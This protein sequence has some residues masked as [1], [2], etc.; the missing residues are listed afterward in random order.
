MRPSDSVDPAVSVLP[1]PGAQEKR[2]PES[3]FRNDI[4]G[5]R[6]FT[7]LAIVGWHISMPGVSGGFVGPDI[8]FE[9]SGFVITGQLWR[10]VSTTG[11]VGLRKFY[12]ARSRRLLPVSA[13]VGVITAV[14]AA[15]LLPQ[16]QAQGALKDAIAC[17][18]YV[19]NFWFIV[20]QVDYF[21][22]G[23]PS[24]FQHYWTLGVEEQFYLLWPPMIV[25]LAWL[26]RRSRRRA[27]A[28]APVRAPSKTPYLIL[29]TFIAVTSFLLSWLV[30]YVMPLAAYF[31]LFTRAWQLA[32]GALVALTA[33]QWRRLPA[34]AAVATGWIGLGMVLLACAYYTPDIPYPG[35][36]ALLP[37]L[38]TALLLAAG[39]STP[40][41]G[42]GRLLGW[43]PMRATGR[44]SYSWYLWHWPVLVFAP[45]VVGHPLGLAGRF[46]AAVVVSGALGWLT[47]RYIENPLRYAAALRKSPMKS[48]AVGGFATS[49]AACVG[50]VLLLWVQS[51]PMP[52]AVG[53]GA[54]AAALTI[55]AP[56]VPTGDN[57]AAY[58]AAVQN[59]FAQ[60]QAAVAASADVK[61]VPSN[62]NPSLAD[63]SGEVGRMMFGGCLRM[64]VQA[65]QPECA[66]GDTASKTTVAVVGDSHASMW[67]PAFE[68]IGSQRPWRIETMAKAACPMMD[69]P[70]AN[71]IAAPIVEAIQHCEQWRGQI[72]A[73]LSAEH[74]RLVILSVFRGYTAS[75]SNGFLSGFSSYDHAWIDGMTRL[76]Q[77]LRGIGAKVLVLGPLPHLE[78][79]VPG[80]LSEHL[81]DA[82]AC[83]PPMSSAF[84]RAGMA[85]ESAAVKAG[86]GQYVDLSDLFCTKNR[87]PVIVGNTLV[88]VDAGHL[89]LEYSRLLAPAIAAL[90]DRALAR[91]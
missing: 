57:E 87:C 76:V 47:L 74:P 37:V 69:L 38:G 64:P 52:V 45:I 59:V 9:I 79:A 6:G 75:H 11:T 8:F 49:A 86:G 7:L 25:G 19:P 56:P 4:E 82:T 53:H 51:Q 35:T 33:D 18:L 65:G 15:F 77:Q 28:G 50:V 91:G 24:P 21:A 48:L 68:Q 88:Y 83:S 20:Q 14:V 44:L 55:K 31:S 17:A 1:A 62:L 34:R 67:I 71:R 81:S 23:A 42:A 73:R 78:T 32:L 36:A 26:I 30:T 12:G 89:T 3:G 27:K 13:T 39:C 22:G 54:P 2:T 61:D 29:V 60:V 43:S 16:V 66:L 80:C 5:L 63:A 10:Q 85:A 58:D 41:Q 40:N 46:I 84:D 72:M 70:I 90:A